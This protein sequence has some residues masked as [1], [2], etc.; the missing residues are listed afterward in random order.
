MIIQDAFFGKRAGIYMNTLLSLIL[1]TL[2]LFFT[3]I[4]MSDT[5]IKQKEVED[6]TGQKVSCYAVNCEKGYDILKDLSK[7][8]DLKMKDLNSIMITDESRSASYYVRPFGSLWGSIS[9]SQQESPFEI[10]K[11]IELIP[12]KGTSAAQK[13]RANETLAKQFFSKFEQMFGKNLRVSCDLLDHEDQC[14]SALKKFDVVA[15]KLKKEDIAFEK[16]EF[17]TYSKD[18]DENGAIVLN[19]RLSPDGMLSILQ[20]QPSKFSSENQLRLSILTQLNGARQILERRNLFAACYT[21]SNQ[22]CL[23]AFSELE[24]A[25]RAHPHP[26]RRMVSFFIDGSQSR[27]ENRTFVMPFSTRATEI[28]KI[29]S[30]DSCK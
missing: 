12:N 18:M 4:G 17:S 28:R 1:V 2:T 20:F 14:L 21:I 27:F 25:S 15:S 30:Q 19:F 23:K 29:L 24:T 11:L 3:Q 7:T 13:H 8:S 10:S 5:G 16:V 6:L 26:C 22:E 9:F